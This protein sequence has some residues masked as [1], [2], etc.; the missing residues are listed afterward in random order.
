MCFQS[1]LYVEHSLI[2]VIVLYVRLKKEVR[3]ILYEGIQDIRYSKYTLYKA[4]AMQGLGV[5]VDLLHWCQFV[6]QNLKQGFLDAVCDIYVTIKKY[7]G[8][9]YV[10]LLHWFMPIDGSDFTPGT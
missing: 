2:K 6:V 9:I 3:N 5:Y 10:T 7:I 8:D 1:I 4:F